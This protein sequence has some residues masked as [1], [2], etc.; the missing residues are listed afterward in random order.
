MASAA[1]QMGLSCRRCS[2]TAV[3]RQMATSTARPAVRSVPLLLV[4]LFL[5]LKLGH[6]ALAATALRGGVA[7][8]KF[9]TGIPMVAW[10]SMHYIAIA[11]QGYPAT[12]V[13]GPENVCFFPVLPLL[14]RVLLPVLGAALAVL[15]V[16]NVASVAGLLMF[17]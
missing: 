12:A 15:T 7:D 3:E 16:A 13:G 4:V 11:E 9:A 5:A 10:D 6:F 1:P 14:S 8:P 2:V 17:Y